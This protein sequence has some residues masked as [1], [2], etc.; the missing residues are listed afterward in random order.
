MPSFTPR[1][2]PYPSDYSEPSDV[3]AAVEALAV[4]IDSDVQ[5]RD[6]DFAG[7]THD[8]RYYT[9]AEADG[10]LAGKSP[11]SH[12]HDAYTT[13]EVDSLLAG[14]EPA[15]SSIVKVA[16]SLAG[17]SDRR[18]FAIVWDV[19]TLGPD[20][21][22]TSPTYTVPAGCYVVCSV[23]HFSN[24]LNAVVN[25]TSTTTFD[26]QCR[27]STAN[28]THSGIKIHAIIFNP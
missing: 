27:N 23:Q 4:A 16:S 20:S 24:Y 13:G 15:D 3:P 9:E 2:Y 8:D 10:L 19:G 22:V 6:N 25:F 14:K 28:T 26:L 18:I 17:V 7:H 21:E 5:G 1:G 12:T 11:T